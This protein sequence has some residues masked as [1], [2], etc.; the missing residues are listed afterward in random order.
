MLSG[1]GIL[2]LGSGG[3]VVFEGS[4]DGRPVAVKRLLR[5]FYDLAASEIRTLILSDEHVN[6]VRYIAMEEDAQFCYLALERCAG[7]LND[8]L[9]GGGRCG[10]EEGRKAGWQAEATESVEGTDGALP[11]P[12]SHHRRPRRLAAADFWD[13]A[14]GTPSALR[15]CASRPTHAAA[16]QRCTRAASCIATSSRTT[17]CSPPPAA[18]SC[19]TWGSAA[20][21]SPTRSASR[22]WAQVG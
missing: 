21:S 11:S 14:T 13:A 8:V 19:R 1:S 10:E 15:R 6:V 3:T 2:G 22:R 4:L 20:A 12:A 17:S 7:S 18:P 5:Q 9:A 16:W